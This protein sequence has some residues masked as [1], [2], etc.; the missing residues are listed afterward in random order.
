M[1]ESAPT[2][3]LGA[4]R[5]YVKA[6][7]HTVRHPSGGGSDRA[8]KGLCG[9]RPSGAARPQAGGRSTDLTR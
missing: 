8:L 9:G 5:H 3:Q 7:S 2:G 4:P 1:G 6:S